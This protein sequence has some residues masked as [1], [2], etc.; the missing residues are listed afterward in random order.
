MGHIWWSRP[1]L[2]EILA[3]EVPVSVLWGEHDDIFPVDHGKM[4]AHVLGNKT[5]LYVVKGAEHNPAHT[6]SAAVGACIGDAVRKTVGAPRLLC[7]PQAAA[8]RRTG[9]SNSSGSRS[10]SESDSDGVEEGNA[11]QSSGARPRNPAETQPKLGRHTGM[12]V[13]RLAPGPAWGTEEMH[14]Q[15]ACADSPAETSVSSNGGAAG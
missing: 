4:L 9:R 6:D 8:A 7:G 14:L 11:A 2:R 3:L 1:V 13:E 12:H 5:D 10:S 15:A